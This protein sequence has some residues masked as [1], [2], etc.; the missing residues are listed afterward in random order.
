MNLLEMNSTDEIAVLFISGTHKSAPYAKA[1]FSLF[2]KL[3]G[4]K[5]FIIDV[6]EHDSLEVL[7]LLG[8]SI[9]PQLRVYRGND[10]VHSEKNP[11]L[12]SRYYG[13]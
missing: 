8:V 9:T 7:D 1:Q 6:D 5:A 13:L 3:F 2:K 4:S 11:S 12:F 10:I